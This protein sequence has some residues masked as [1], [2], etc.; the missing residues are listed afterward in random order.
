[1]EIESITQEGVLWRIAYR[2]SDNH[3]VYSYYHVNK[4]RDEL[5][6]WK[7]WKE[8]TNASDN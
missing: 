5:D 2:R 6:V 7:W 8:Q 1:M 3:T 4:F